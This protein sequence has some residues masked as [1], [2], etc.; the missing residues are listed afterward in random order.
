M[1]H[2]SIQ[3]SSNLD[4]RVDFDVFC[5]RI[6]EAVL[7][8]GLFEVGSVR[9]RAFRADSYAIANQH[10]ENAFIDMYFRIGTGRSQEEIEKAG[11]HIFA[12]ASSELTGFFE[13]PHFA[14][15]LEIREIDPVLSWRRNAMHARLGQAAG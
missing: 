15:S 14:L 11:K 5:S 3:Y 2:L 1:P 7:E 13:A 9:V 10:P 6:L 8:T 12:H 4:G